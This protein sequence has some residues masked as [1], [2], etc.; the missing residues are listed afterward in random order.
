MVVIYVIISGGN[1]KSL[2]GLCRRLAKSVDCK[3]AAKVGQRVG[4]LV[5]VRSFMGEWL[6]LD[7]A[8]P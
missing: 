7:G 5:Q 1:K 8:G 2:R 3:E 6:G 4:R